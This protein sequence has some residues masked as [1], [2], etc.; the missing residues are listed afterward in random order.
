MD[1]PFE[2]ACC[3]CSKFTLLILRLIVL[4]VLIV[5]YPAYFRLAATLGHP[6][7]YKRLLELDDSSGPPP[8]EA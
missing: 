8:I 6:R 7:P 1:P 4:Q 3:I 5:E 2:D